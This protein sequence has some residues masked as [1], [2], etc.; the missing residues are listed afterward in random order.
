MNPEEPPIK[1]VTP[2]RNHPLA[3]PMH[4]ASH[5][6]MKQAAKRRQGKAAAA[7][8]AA[9][10]PLDPQ[11][12]RLL[13]ASG[14]GPGN[15]SQVVGSGVGAGPPS[16][17]PQYLTSPPWPNEPLGYQMAAAGGAGPGHWP[18][19]GWGG[20]A[21]QDAL[22]LPS[23]RPAE[24]GAAFM[25]P[26]TGQAYMGFTQPMPEPKVQ[27]ERPVIRLGQ[28]SRLLEALT[29]VSALTRPPRK[30]MLVDWA[31]EVEV[32][33]APPEASR[34]PAIRARQAQQAAGQVFFTREWTEQTE[35]EQGPAAGMLGDYQMLRPWVDTQ[36]MRDNDEWGPQLTLMQ[37]PT[38]WEGGVS[39]APIHDLALSVPTFMLRPDGKPGAPAPVVRAVDELATMAASEFPRATLGRMRAEAGRVTADAGAVPLEGA[40]DPPAAAQFMT[41]VDVSPRLE[42]AG[43]AHSVFESPAAAP[44]AGSW[45]QAGGPMSFDLGRPGAGGQAFQLYGELGTGTAAA[46]AAAGLPSARLETTGGP[47]LWR[48]GGVDPAP[49]PEW[50]REFGGGVTADRVLPGVGASALPEGRRDLPP[51]TADLV[52]GVQAGRVG[53]GAAGVA[54]LGAHLRDDAFRGFTPGGMVLSAAA[55]RLAVLANPFDGAAADAAPSWLPRAVEFAGDARVAGPGTAAFT[56]GHHVADGGGGRPWTPA[57]SVLLAALDRVVDGR[58]GVQAE[59]PSQ[60]PQHLVPVPGRVEAGRAG[61]Q[62]LTGQDPAGG[63]D[64]LGQAPPRLD[65]QSARDARVQTGTATWAESPGGPQGGGPDAAGGT[66]TARIGRG[67]DLAGGF[68][69]AGAVQ[70]QAGGHA[71]HAP[72]AG[73]RGTQVGYVLPGGGGYAGMDGV[74]QLDPVPRVIGDEGASFARALAETGAVPRQVERVHEGAGADRLP[75]HY[76]DGPSVPDSDRTPQLALASEVYYRTL[77]QGAQPDWARRGEEYRQVAHP[78]APAGPPAPH[79]AA[80]RD[81][82]N[83]ARRQVAAASSAHAARLAAVAA[84]GADPVMAASAAACESEYDSA[85]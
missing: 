9:P 19:P 77:H 67:P 75:S 45:A 4:A 59:V 84:R 36:T 48:L 63:A 3:T 47:N 85:A 64:Y 43:A 54:G 15:A 73:P 68:G 78:A 20:A 18:T 26:A 41:W 40:G 23:D 6:Y 1:Y 57:G 66:T 38:E 65:Q 71:S 58:G 21:D 50:Q 60:V 28:P 7:V 37:K 69:T 70:V 31:T 25:D 35:Y 5:Y 13:Y 29:G 16:T 32:D 2:R 24:F 79:L 17:R 83:P 82:G 76:R 46:A 12:S 62:A 61:P 51:P 53:L 55:E 49:V 8:A 72:P 42:V 33:W 81:A 34:M 14:V 30:E 22:P 80:V 56:G 39:G 44:V 52:Q 11:H 74:R 10:G 27:Y